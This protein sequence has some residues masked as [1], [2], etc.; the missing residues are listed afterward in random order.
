MFQLALTSNLEC[1]ITLN[2][3]TALQ[4][5]VTPVIEI[6][7]S[8]VRLTPEDV[9]CILGTVCDG[10]PYLITTIMIMTQS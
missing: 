3:L 6:I 4:V 1:D 7:G 5:N 9:V 10:K 2:L 8:G